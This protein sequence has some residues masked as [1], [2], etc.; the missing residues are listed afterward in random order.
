M[1]TKS[2][3]SLKNCLR[4]NLDRE[5]HFSIDRVAE[6]LMLLSAMTS[7]LAS[8]S[9]AL[10]AHSHLQ[11]SRAGWCQY[12]GYN[13]DSAFSLF[14]AFR[15]KKEKRKIRQSRY[16]VSS[17]FS[18]TSDVNRWNLFPSPIESALFSLLGSQLRFQHNV[19]YNV[20]L[21]P[22]A[23]H[24]KASFSCKQLDSPM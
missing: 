8:Q 24:S 4:I 3:F 2:T 19:I 10:K 20:E 6:L 22:S 12:R 23:W 7:S 17:S 1:S 13:I 9:S 14:I 16:L 5:A 11:L 15:L 18:M 21:H